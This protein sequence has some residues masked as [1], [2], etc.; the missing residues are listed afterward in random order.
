ME[1]E[2]VSSFKD[3]GMHISEDFTWMLNT[4]QLLNNALQQ[5]Y[6]MR[7]LRRFGMSPRILR[8]FHRC[9]VESVL[10]NNISV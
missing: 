2:R 6:F 5:L 8:N 4:A 10:T 7:R 9:V 3:L 1:E